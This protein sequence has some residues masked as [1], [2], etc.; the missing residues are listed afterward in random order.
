MRAKG[1]IP[2]PAP[3]RLANSNSYD[4]REGYYSSYY[5]AEPFGQG[6]DFIHEVSEEGQGPSLPPPKVWPSPR[7]SP[8]AMVLYPSSTHTTS[9]ESS[10]SL[11]GSSPRSLTQSKKLRMLTL[12]IEDRRCGTDELAEIRVPLKAAGEGYFWADAKEVCMA[13]QSGPSRV[14]GPAKLFTMR[15]KYRQTFL[16]ISLGG[17]ETCQSAHLNVNPD[18][19]LPVVVD[20]LDLVLMPRFSSDPSPLISTGLITPV[21][22][23]AHPLTPMSNGL[24]HEDIPAN[25][26][27]HKESEQWAG[28]VRKRK[29]EM[30]LIHEQ[31]LSGPQ[32]GHNPRNPSEAPAQT[33]PTPHG[34]HS[35]SRKS[36]R[37][38]LITSLD[39]GYMSDSPPAG[40]HWYK[41]QRKDQAPFGSRPHRV[42]YE[43]DQPSSSVRARAPSGVMAVQEQ[44]HSSGRRV[45]SPLQPLSTPFE[46][47]QRVNDK[48]ISFLQGKFMQDISNWNEFVRDRALVGFLSNAVLLRVYWFA[49]GQV[50]DWVGTRTP[51]HL[52]YKTVE[53]KH[54]LVALG[55]TEG[56]YEECNETLSLAIA[57]G[58]HG[59][60]CEDPRAVAASRDCTPK[61][62]TPSP[63]PTDLLVLLRQVHDEYCKRVTE[64][65][66]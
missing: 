37:G 61:T 22:N 4:R 39:G 33:I 51:E 56:W 44:Y 24:D 1:V 11:V 15:G 27:N 29:R 63:G 26:L 34:H 32:E 38:D 19:T 53:V 52:N 14:D 35:R 5:D 31:P 46:S 17:E 65:D 55:V 12:L 54:V 45:H 13:L 30:S 23:V 21:S 60:R 6:N 42:E 7:S 50:D 64:R 2:L 62:R 20:T 8:S 57:Y 3:P 66:E 25:P 18:R 43:T 28:N 41:V 36:R 10:P 49:Q 16:R 48:I 47:A 58:E 59:E 40:H 9:K